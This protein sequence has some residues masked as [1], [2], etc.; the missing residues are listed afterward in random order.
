MKPKTLLFLLVIGSVAIY[1]GLKGYVYFSVK[2]KLD[3]LTRRATPFVT[4]TYGEI[5]SDLRG[6]VTVKDAAA[7]PV[8]T[9]LEFRAEEVEIEGPDLAFLLA[10]SGDFKSSE[11][12]DHMRLHFRGV[13]IPSD[14][15]LM[16]QLSGLSARSGTQEK[17]PVPPKVC[18]L[19]GIFQHIGMERIGYGTLPM[20]FSIGYD[21]YRP[22]NELTINSNYSHTGLDSLDWKMVFK[23]MPQAD[24][25]MQ[26]VKPELGR[27]EG[28]YRVDR[29][30]MKRMVDYCAKQAKVTPQ[31]YVDS[32]FHQP[33]DYYAR[34]LGII[35]GE[36]IRSALKSLLSG[37]TELSFSAYPSIEITAQMFSGYQ[38]D[39]LAS[40]LGVQM[41]VDGKRVPDISFTVPNNRQL[42][43]EEKSKDKTS[44]PT[45]AELRA[46]R[47]PLRYIKTKLADLGNYLGAMVQLHVKYEPQ[48][49]TG[50]LDKITKD[51]VD[52]QQRIYGGSITVHIPIKS[53]ES[54]EVLRRE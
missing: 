36:G 1:A 17:R 44:T 2:G 47:K 14:E 19:G 4:L 25:I 49:R 52:V 10:L 12:P 6:K 53:I 45:E 21:Y 9:T 15:D 31:Q 13:S 39:E 23:N 33:D 29:T 48:P 41:S 22:A 3:D 8:G 40:L 46:K 5:E 38:P 50:I 27:M 28:S 37:A 18:S 16:S 26:G 43:A 32:L 54:V 11:A 42:Y 34:N 51:I 7:M 20:D 30:Y 24:Q 35:P